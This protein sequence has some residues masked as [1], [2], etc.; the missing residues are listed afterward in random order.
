MGLP[1]EE[2]KRQWQRYK[3]IKAV[4]NNRVYVIDSDIIC[5]PTPVS[6]A[7]ALEVVAELIH[8]EGEG[9]GYEKKR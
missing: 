5:S 7:Y 8:P 4:K 1:G 2:E 9:K 3:G 6:F